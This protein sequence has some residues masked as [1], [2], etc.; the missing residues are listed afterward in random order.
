MTIN[1]QMNQEIQDYLTICRW[2]DEHLEELVERETY[3]AQLELDHDLTDFNHL[4]EA[5]FDYSDLS[6]G[7]L[8]EWEQM[9]RA[10]M[11]DT[12]GHVL[13]TYRLTQQEMIKMELK[14]RV[15]A[16]PWLALSFP[17]ETLF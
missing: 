13:S 7:E 11:K 4:D 17:L 2:E 6:F 10:S 8:K 15:K 16:K 14:S 3:Q 1:N 5:V 9:S 12:E